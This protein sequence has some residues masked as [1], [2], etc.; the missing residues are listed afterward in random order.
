LVDEISFDNSI[1]S[2]SEGGGGYPDNLQQFR[3]LI[4]LHATRVHILR[5]LDGPICCSAYRGGC[6]NKYQYVLLG[7]TSWV[8][9]YRRLTHSTLS[10]SLADSMSTLSQQ[11]PFLLIGLTMHR[12]AAT[13]R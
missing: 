1:L 6:A 9:A 8:V 10:V 11:L 7:L 3:D 4:D 5:V 2:N 12:R 13:S